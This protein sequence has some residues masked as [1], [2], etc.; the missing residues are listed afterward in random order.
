MRAAVHARAALV[1]ATA[2]GLG[3]CA[4]TIPPPGGPERHEP[5]TILAF[6]PETSAVNVR[7]KEADIQFDE[8]VSQ[9]PQGVSDLSGLFLVSPYAGPPDVGW[10]RSRISIRPR[11]GFRANTVYTI[12]MLPGLSDLRNNVRRTGAVL[13][14]STG[15]T[16]PS[17]TV[18]GRV[19]DWIA[20]QPAP[21][22]L[23]QAVV[24]SDT[25][26][27]YV[28]QADSTGAFLMRHLPPG[29]YIVRGVVDANHNHVLDPYEMWDSVA[30]DLV[31]TARVELLA[32]LHDTIG[33]RITEVTVR[34]SVTLRVT[35]DRG[36][37]TAQRIDTAL[38][39]LKGRDSVR[40]PLVAARSGAAYDSA[41]DSAARARG[42]SAFRADSIRRGA[43]GLAPSDTAAARLRRERAASRR[44]SIARAR[45]P[46]P[47]KPPPVH[48]V[49]VQVGAP[50]HAGT[51]YRLTA[52]GV[53]GLL[54]KSRT[55]DRV[56]SVP[57]PDSLRARAEA[58]SVRRRRGPAG[59]GGPPSAQPGG[60]PGRQEPRPARPPARDTTAPSPAP[61]DSGRRTRAGAAPLR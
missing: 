12:T 24:R 23:V 38:F 45:I 14:F 49:V 27:V 16:I 43:Q 9:R 51:Y 7:V 21:R 32:F 46:H 5:P 3:A 30:V 4:A 50:L 15:P 20:A 52:I 60:A 40:I 10:H 22:A 26:V 34:D 53:R 41:V 44:D 19:F 29:P 58:D 48:E 6:T 33:P 61:S 55:S 57:K 8:V 59:A 39:A 28:T 18:Y 25:T 17:T 54:G 42:D 2:L 37:D 36:I 13:T 56:F 47:S 31:D 35:F 1:G 11:K